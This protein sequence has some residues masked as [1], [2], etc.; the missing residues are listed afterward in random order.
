MRNKVHI[1]YGVYSK[2]I[3][4]NP[5][6]PIIA[7]NQVQ[8]KDKHLQATE[9]SKWQGKNTIQQVSIILYEQNYSFYPFDFAIKSNNFTRQHITKG[10]DELKL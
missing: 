3:Q 2:G 7:P 8:Q 9:T 6:G 10:R 5:L 1:L 4:N